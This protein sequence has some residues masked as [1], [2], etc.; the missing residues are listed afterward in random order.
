MKNI[1]YLAL[2]LLGGQLINGFG[3]AIGKALYHLING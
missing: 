2:F 3:V 1:M